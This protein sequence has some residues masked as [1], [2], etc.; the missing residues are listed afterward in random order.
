MVELDAGALHSLLAQVTLSLPVLKE[1]CCCWPVSA[2]TVLGSW[3]K[4]SPWPRQEVCK[5]PL[6]NH[7]QGQNASMR[8][9]YWSCFKFCS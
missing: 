8:Q 7:C 4:V 1:H 9:V 3:W 5:G 6:I 2:E